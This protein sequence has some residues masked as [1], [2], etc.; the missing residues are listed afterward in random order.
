MKKLTRDRVVPIIS[1]SVSWLNFPTIGSGLPSLPKFARR[2]S[3]RARRF[4]LELNNWSI[5]SSSIRLIPRQKVRHEQFRKF[6]LIMNGRDH[7]RP[8]QASYH[9]FIDRHSGRD[10]QRLAIQTSFA[11]KVTGS[12]DR[13]YRFPALLGN[14]SEFYPALLDVENR[15]RDLSLWENNLIFS[16]F[17]YCFSL[18]H[19]GEKYFGIKRRLAPLLHNI[20]FS[21]PQP[22]CSFPDKG[23][24]I[25]VNI[26]ISVPQVKKM[27]ITTI[28]AMAV[29]L[30]AARRFTTK[31]TPRNNRG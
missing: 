31:A 4:S 7:S 30:V 10:S 25:Q 13:D 5:K 3:S 18:A 15:V 20:T 21:L 26:A 9:A 1:A 23:S 8:L 27:I 11:K 2:R 22:N 17:G 6:R 28:T 14:D 24:G 16:I 29:I 12:Q 19:F